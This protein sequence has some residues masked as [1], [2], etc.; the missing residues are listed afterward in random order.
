MKEIKKTMKKILSSLLTGM[1]LGG[2]LIAPAYAAN[3]IM[4]FNVDCDT[5]DQVLRIGVTTDPTDVDNGK[6]VIA[7]QFTFDLKAIGTTAVADLD[8]AEIIPNPALTNMVIAENTK[9]QNGSLHRIRVAG[10]FTGQSGIKNDD[11]FILQGTDKK[12]FEITVA[13][14]ELYEQDSLDNFYP[15]SPAQQLN[16]NPEADCAPPQDN[17]ANTNNGGSSQTANQ[18]TISIT[19]DVPNNTASPGDNVIVTGIITNRNNQAISW[20]Q[21]TGSQINPTTQDSEQGGGETRSDLIFTVPSNITENETIGLVLSV[22]QGAEAVSETFDLQVEAN[23]R[24]SADTTNTDESVQ[25]RIEERRQQAQEQTDQSQQNQQ[26]TPTAE[27][28]NIHSSA[29]LPNSGPE[30]IWMLLIFSGVV[31]AG[32]QKMKIY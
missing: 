24:G 27:A 17:S 31:L 1:F 2:Q 25:Q 23:L 29:G 3:P 7:F 21:S 18:T 6:E 12:A 19:S 14:G 15:D 8:N 30:H 5:A 10:G 20:V 32:Y 22:G 13:D 11:L 28:G 4:N 26:T 16:I 9:S